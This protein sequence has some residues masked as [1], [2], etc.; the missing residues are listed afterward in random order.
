MCF[1]AVHNIIN[2]YQSA[3]NLDQPK[4]QKNIHNIRDKK[5]CLTRY[6][7]RWFMIF[8][9]ISRSSNV[10]N[11][12]TIHHLFKRITVFSFTKYWWIVDVY[13]DYKLRATKSRSKL[14]ESDKLGCVQYFSY[15]RVLTPKQN[16]FYFFI[17]MWQ[18]IRYN[19]LYI[20][21]GA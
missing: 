13:A 1:Q 17:N 14:N 2:H 16:W 6:L 11:T 3:V 5:P 7:A 19:I 10:V 15:D 20:F 8:N 18:R 4:I 9:I 21:C 12:F